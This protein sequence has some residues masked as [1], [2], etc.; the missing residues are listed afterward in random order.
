M[1]TGSLAFFSFSIGFFC[2]V[3]FVCVCV[4]AL[5][6]YF[7]FIILWFVKIYIVLFY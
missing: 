6:I 3:L 4:C 5:L 2:S 1:F 7:L